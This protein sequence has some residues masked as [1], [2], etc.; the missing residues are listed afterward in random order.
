MGFLDGRRWPWIVSALAAGH[1]VFA[2][3]AMGL[4]PEHVA[5]DA[6]ITLLAWSGPRGRRFTQLCLP[7]WLVGVSYDSLRLMSGWKGPV[8]V[9]ELYGAELSWFGI[10]WDGRSHIPSDYFLEHTS[11]VLDLLC[12]AAYIGYLLEPILFFL[13]FTIADGERAKRLVWGFLVLNVL[14]ITTYLLYPAA[15]PWY[16]QRYGLGP[17]RL[18]VPPSP[19]GAVRFDALTGIGLF[20]SFYARNPNV[21]GAMPSLHAAYPVLVL[22]TVAGMG[23]FWVAGCSLFA[24]L[25]AFSAVY[26]RHHYVWDVLVGWLYA[27]VATLAVRA[28]MER[29]P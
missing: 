16:V 14:G 24:L 28:A 15:P 3:V 21:F 2:A 13:Y 11:P 27:V 17:A 10:S 19:A 18:D 7:L 4:R 25:V 23:A 12:G 9:D 20:S 1:L 8:R 22:G 29:R 5:G 26:L 6:L